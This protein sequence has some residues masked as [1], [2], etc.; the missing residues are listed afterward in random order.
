M[1]E[2]VF[3]SESP[4][5]HKICF[6][7]PSTF[8]DKL[9]KLFEKE[10]DS[11][12]ALDTYIAKFNQNN[13]GLISEYY[14]DVIDEQNVKIG[15]LFKHLFRA[16]GVSRKYA[17]CMI[18]ITDDKINVKFDSKLDVDLKSQGSCGHMP[19]VFICASYE[20][21]GDVL[22]STIEYE[23]VDDVKS[24]NCYSMVIDSIREGICKMI[25]EIELIN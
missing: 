18:N 19:L 17:K 16:L 25:S 8:K 23:T 9:T 24:Y 10:K 11:L 2:L 6:T 14:Y 1:N 15:I 3:S 4:T 22:K 5:K 13:D 12:T 21:C 7:T 20:I